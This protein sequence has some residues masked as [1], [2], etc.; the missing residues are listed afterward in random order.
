MINYNIDI[1]YALELLLCCFLASAY[2]VPNVKH[3]V[4]S[5]R[6][7]DKPNERSSHTHSTPSLGGIAFYIT[8]IFAL[9]FNDK[10]D[11]SNTLI[12]LLPGL[13][14]MFFM[15]LKDDLVGSSPKIKFIS[16]ILA[17]LFIIEN[18]CFQLET[19]HG[20]FGIDIIPIWISA[21]LSV[22]IM[23][24]IIN[25]YNLIDGIDGLAASISTVALSFFAVLFFYIGDN[26][27][28]LTAIAMIGTL[29][30]FL[31]FN[32][33][34]QRKIFMGDTGSL[35]IGFLIAVMSIRML[36]I[37]ENET[38]NLIPF[39]QEYIPILM[40]TFILIPIFDVVR[41][42]II[43]IL[44]NRNP[45]SADRYHFHHIMV[46]KLN[47][48]HRRTAFAICCMNFTIIILSLTLCLKDFGIINL[49]IL[50]AVIILFM[51]FILTR[52]SKEIESNKENPNLN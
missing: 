8:F 43:R 52:W 23:I 19:L 30:G 10:Y 39:K 5:K 1:I 9:F 45:L 48:S 28:A 16:Q 4:Y 6:L 31:F 26:F 18:P 32:L 11:T 41:L 12:S 44:Q 2:L 7:M 33:S 49:I 38:L 34:E 47:W 37:N 51:V 15:G 35:I 25:A 17:S 46:D 40:G 13:T 50:L 29:L 3:I 14:L 21:P 42:F 27:L 22:L 24:T 20:L 36:T